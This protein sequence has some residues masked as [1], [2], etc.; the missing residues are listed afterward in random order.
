MDLTAWAL[1]ALMAAVV[2]GGALLH[3][4]RNEPAGRGRI[5]LAALRG[6]A[7]AVLTLLLF[8]PMVPT[9]LAEPRL[10]IAL[11]DGSLSMRLPSPDG[12]TRWEEA[13]RVVAG[14]GADRVLVFGGTDAVAV[15]SVEEA[16]PRAPGSRLAPALRAAL[17][18]GA[19]RVVVVTDGALEDPEEAARLL[20][21]HG[22]LAAVHRVGERTAGNLAV[23]ELESPGWAR[24]GEAVEVRAGIG[25]LGEGVPD[26]V[27]VALRHEGQVLARA[28]AAVPAEGRVAPAVLRFVPRPGMEGLVRLDV[29]L[30]VS[31]AEPADDHRSLYLVVAEQPAG[32]VLVSF[33]PGQ[34]PRFLLPVVER[35]V[36]LPTRG[37]LAVGG[38]RF[39]RV[40]M[41]AE[42]GAVDAEQDVRRAVAEADL[43]VLHG[44]DDRSPEWA[45]RAAGARATLVLPAGP[46]SE[47]PVR[48]GAARPGEW[49]PS[50]ELPP[51]PAGPFLTGAVPDAAPPLDAVR[52][53]ETPPGWWA[54]L[55][56]RQDR[57]GD[58]S[59]VLVAGEAGGRRMAVA[60]GE[61]YW[62]WAFFDDRSRALYRAFWSGVASWLMGAAPVGGA[63][64]ARPETQV[65]PRGEPLRWVVPPDA[66]SL[67]VVLRAIADP[68]GGRLDEPTVAADTVLAAA[69]GA[70][71]Q[72]PPAPG[73]YRYE[74]RVVG[75]GREAG[76][77]GGELTVER[78][79]PE[80]TRPGGA[81][82]LGTGA[83]EPAATAAR[84]GRPLRASPW[85]YVVLVA[86][87][88]GEWVLRR[89]WGLR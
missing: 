37:W 34:E 33:R 11:V 78:Y 7:L 9:R 73:H 84:V 8:D 53:A 40:G 12:T 13:K 29:G 15:G 43:L 27:T 19:A 35:A 49:Y 31:D 18:A 55:H 71:V 17:E 30:E 5:L 74:A 21:G 69:R 41:G 65:V 59:P 75:D 81:L 58:P 88:C 89:R 66:E 61:G 50:P 63:D 70:A 52:A 87:L 23:A 36:G 38:D 2:L 51:S 62:R 24:A 44:V 16:A 77:A 80:F 60:L 22:V 20:G 86:L 64:L 54:P 57:R 42:A 48:L 45:R 25:R 79:S 6:L 10:A 32:V 1:Y 28:R 85:P 39:I 67:R 47:A 3:Y 72:R 56:V 14:T 83:V 26:S 4:R 46:V 68:A 76:V 82:E